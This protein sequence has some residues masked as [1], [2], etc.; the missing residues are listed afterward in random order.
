MILFKVS[1]RDTGI[2]T[3]HKKKFVVLLLVHDHHKVILNFL[4]PYKVIVLNLKLIVF[5]V[6]VSKVLLE[7]EKNSVLCEDFIHIMYPYYM[8]L[9]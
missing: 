3:N 4:Y 7:T 9:L 2:S 6:S 8:S 5:K 1:S